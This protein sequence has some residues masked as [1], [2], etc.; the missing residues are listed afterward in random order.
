MLL[1]SCSRLLSPLVHLSQNQDFAKHAPL[2]DRVTSHFRGKLALIDELIHTKDTE[3][4]WTWSEEAME[5][6]DEDVAKATLARLYYLRGHLLVRMNQKPEAEE[7]FAR[8]VSVYPNRKGNGAILNLL[9][10]Y[11]DKGD[12]ANY[13]K[14]K[15]TYFLDALADVTEPGI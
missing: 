1:E 14:I 13:Q 3:L 15:R 7:S 12:R 6:V 4:L 11:A 10:L 5:L 9:E 8:S 2:L